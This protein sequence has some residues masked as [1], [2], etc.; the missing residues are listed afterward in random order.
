MRSAMC[1]TAVL[2]TMGCGAGDY[3]LAPV[4]GTVTLDGKPVAGARVIFEPQRSG[5]EALS[6]GP[7]SDGITDDDGRYSLRTTADGQ[8]GAVV[9]NHSVTISTFHA[10][11]DRSRDSSRVIRKE[12]IPSRFFEP[13]SLVYEVPPEGTDRANFM[14]Q[15]P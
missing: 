9:G 2:L 4:S 5:Q 6:A 7:G 15:T 10:E 1:L 3:D 12:E 11:A 8:R 14:L 13:G